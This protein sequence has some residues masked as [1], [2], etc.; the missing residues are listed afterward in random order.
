MSVQEDLS[1]DLPPGSRVLVFAAHPDDPEFGCGGTLARWTKQGVIA[2]ICICT[3]GNKGAPTMDMSPAQLAE[4]RRNEQRAAADVLGVTDLFFL[5]NPDAELMPTL[6]FRGQLVR[7]IRQFRPDAVFTHNV[8][9]FDG[10]GRF[11]N[12]PDHRAVGQTALDAIYPTARDPLHFAEHLAE[13]LQPHKVKHIYLFGSDRPNTW[14]DITESLRAKM[15]ALRCHK[16][17]I[18]E[19]EKLEEMLNHWTA[20]TAKGHGMAHAEAF[21]H[22]DMWM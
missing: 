9:P 12:H 19:P 2:G 7:V 15:D 13:G 5:D 8:E 21:F 6:E 14:I 22:I 11:L 17:Q 3:N 4:V 20:E 16:T 18:H 10:G 1:A